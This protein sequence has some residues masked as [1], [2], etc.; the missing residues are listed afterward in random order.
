MPTWRVDKEEALV[1]SCFDERDRWHK[2]G[3]GRDE[4]QSVVPVIEGVRNDCCRNP[5]I[6]LFFLLALVPSLAVGAFESTAL[7]TDRT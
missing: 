5:H 2:V 1:E 3:I 4:E 7:Q 6:S